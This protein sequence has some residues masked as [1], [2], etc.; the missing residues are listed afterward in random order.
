M[1]LD[2]SILHPNG[3]ATFSPSKTLFWCFLEE[4][5]IGVNM[6]MVQILEEST[7]IQLVPKRCIKFFFC[8]GPRD[9]GV[10]GC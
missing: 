6:T 3:S 8:F 9:E 1:S 4:T 5:T 2:S 10:L 7:N